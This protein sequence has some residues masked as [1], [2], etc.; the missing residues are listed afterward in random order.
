MKARA[1]NPGRSATRRKVISTPCCAALSASNSTITA[2]DGKYKLTQNRDAADRE[3]VRAAYER[4]GRE[5]MARHGLTRL[6]EP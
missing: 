2:L 4:E 3:A 6:N 5:D 1:P